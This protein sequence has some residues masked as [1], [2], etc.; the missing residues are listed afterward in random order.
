LCLGGVAN[1]RAQVT[2]NAK[3]SREIG[4]PRFNPLDPSPSTA[5]PNLV[6]GREFNTP[7]GVAVD[8]NASP[9]PMVYVSDNGNHRVLGWQYKPSL[10]DPTQGKFATAD[11]VIGQVDQYTTVIGGPPL[12]S[13]GLTAPTG[14]AV[15]ASGNLYVVDSGNNRILR[16]PRSGSSVSSSADMV[17]G[18]KSLNANRAIAP[19]ADTLNFGNGALAASLLFDSTG[20]LYVADSG[21]NRVLRFSASDLNAGISGPRANLVLGQNTFTTNDPAQG[22]FVNNNPVTDKLRNPIGLAMDSGG[23]LYVSDGLQRV[24]IYNA[25]TSANGTPAA[26]VLG[27]VVNSSAATQDRDSKTQLAGPTGIFIL[28]GDVVGVIDSGLHRI[29]VFPNFNSWQPSLTVPSPQA[30]AVFGQANDFT[31]AKS[32]ANHGNPESSNATF[33]APLFAATT[34]NNEL[35]LADSANHRVLVMPFQGTAI[36]AATRV[37]GQDQFNLNTMNLI[38]GREFRFVFQNSSGI[39]ADGS[40]VIDRQSNP[41]H[42][43]V[44]DTY[45]NRILGFRDARRVQAGVQADLVIGQPDMVHSEANYPTNDA[46]RPDAFSLLQPTGMALDS[47]GNLWVS[48]RGNH[49]VLRFPSPFASQT[50]LQPADLVLG[51]GS[52]TNFKSNS[53][54]PGGMASPYGIALDGDSRL[55]VADQTYNRVVIYENQ[56]GTWNRTKVL[57]QNDFNSIGQGNALNQ[58]RSPTHVATDTDGRVYVADG[59]NGRVLIFPPAAEVMNGDFALSLSIGGLNNPNDVFVNPQTGEI[60]VTD[61]QNS[62]VLRF[63]RFDQLLLGNTGAMTVLGEWSL[64]VAVTQDQFGDLFV[65]DTTNRIVVHYP[66]MLAVN[67]ASYLVA[68]GSATPRPLAPGMNAA[69][70]PPVRIFQPHT[71]SCQA[72]DPQ[73]FGDDSTAAAYTDLPNPVP[74]PTTLADTQVLLNGNP[75]PL[76]MVNS[77]QIN[78]QVP[79]GTSAGTQLLEVVRGSTG[80]TLG[81]TTVSIVPSNPGLYITNITTKDDTRNPQPPAGITFQLLAKNAD[82][83]DNSPTNP[84]A[85]GT[86]VTLFGTGQGVVPGAP[87]DGDV[88]PDGVNTQSKPRVVINP[89]CPGGF[90]PDDSVESS[91][92]PGQIGVWQIKVTI[93]M[94]AIPGNNETFVIDARSNSS[95]DPAKLLTTIAVKQ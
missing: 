92:A 2:L 93:P 8:M 7:V 45:N 30:N 35:F 95:I 72:D 63:P 17:I 83:S 74:L 77:R 73:Q 20:N 31:I 34:K 81:S 42:L 61:T 56:A 25:G 76:F 66:G 53:V 55:I 41:P 68:D 26:K 64:T 84:A 85:R 32:L 88:A 58:M 59:Q 65:A 14:L 24:L 11:V 44:A 16:F 86:V 51:Q 43:Y 62:R 49:R 89:G 1:I 19:D 87:A 69:I 38:E 3:P 28:A 75:V 15:D 54:G 10:G 37:L 22:A 39:F 48:D 29:M 50:A 71:A 6:E 52:P 5:S 27:L 4:H 13:S 23:H 70:C 78:F 57:G 9:F 12:N 82:G 40:I 47:S 60:W 33:A 21:N 91:L 80:Q 36:S 79:M 46:N 67:G 94:C 90:L 18:Q